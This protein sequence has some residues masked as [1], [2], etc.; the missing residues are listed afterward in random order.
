MIHTVADFLDRLRQ[1]ENEAL[2]KQGISHRPT[3]G[4][5]YEGLTQDLLSR[6]LPPSTGIDVVSGFITDASGKQSDELDC[7]VVT[8]KGQEV[9]YTNKRLYL[10]DD[11]AAVIQVKKN[12]YSSD[13]RSGYSNLASVNQFDPTRNRRITLLQDAFQTT[14]RRP[15]PN[16]EDVGKLPYELQLVYQTLV[17]EL[18]YPAR[19]IFG[20]N[21][22]K[23][24]SALRESFVDFLTAHISSGPVPGF[25]V[26][27]IPSLVCCGSHCLVKC[28]GMP[29]SSP[30]QADGFWP[31]ICSTSW[32]PLDLLLQIIWTR[33]TYDNKLP[34]SLF[35]DDVYLEPLTRFIDAHPAHAGDVGGWEYRVADAPPDVIDAPREQD[36]W[37]PV[38]LDQT[39]FVIMNRLCGEG[40]VDTTDS[41]FATYIE[42][43]GYT[44]DGF[45]ESLN[46]VGLAARDGNRLV[47]LTRGCTCAILSDG[48]FVAGEDI[49]DQL[50][51]WMV[52]YIKE[53]NAQQ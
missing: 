19:I 18:F 34:A 43:S 17:M 2:K 39:Q 38:F 24:Q 51:R 8:G 20:Y 45:V 25:G 53:R 11:V 35:D 29:F 42:T 14:T 49:A 46:E 16:R 30:I 52:D 36:R 21:G 9:P 50:T 10:I 48:R 37:Q 32:N 27:D 44:V 6:A 12:L 4:D 15:L 1:R 26:P 31:V 40:S 22:F 7:M 41:D 5:M 33:L 3:I 23:T 13:M 28:N 47:L